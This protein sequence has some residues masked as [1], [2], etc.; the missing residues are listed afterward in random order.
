MP[1]SALAGTQHLEALQRRSWSRNPGRQTPGTRIKARLVP[2][3]RGQVRPLPRQW[4]LGRGLPGPGCARTREGPGGPLGGGQRAEPTWKD[5]LDWVPP[6]RVS[7]TPGVTPTDH[8]RGR[9]HPNGRSGATA[10][11]AH[12]KAAFS[13]STHLDLM[14]FS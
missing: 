3:G 9:E 12:R 4:E 5:G 2:R 14:V 11:G 8:R 10:A 1:C 13:T 7:T 6:L